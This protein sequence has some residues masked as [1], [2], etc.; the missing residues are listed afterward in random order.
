MTTA[1]Q[2]PKEGV[3]TL[4][5]VMAGEREVADALP[6]CDHSIG[7][8]KY[9]A[10]RCPK[11]WKHLSI[12][13]NAEKGHVTSVYVLVKYMYCTVILPHRRALFILLIQ[14]GFWRHPGLHQCSWVT[15]QSVKGMQ[16]QHDQ[17]GYDGYIQG[18]HGCSNGA[19]TFQ[20]ARALPHHMM[21]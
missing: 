8:E 18:K 21:T 16:S 19:R 7:L 14:W 5:D 15:Q 10:E 17:C 6:L 13:W 4:L 9:A 3:C 1:N 11:T 20:R 12:V 2:V